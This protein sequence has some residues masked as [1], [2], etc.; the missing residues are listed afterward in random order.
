MAKRV[1][2]KDDLYTIL[3]FDQAD[4]HLAK[5][6]ALIGERSGYEAAANAMID[7]VKT[8]LKKQVSP[9][10]EKIQKHVRSLEAFC[11]A[12]RSDFGGRQSRSMLFGVVGWRKSTS[13][14][15]KKTTLQKIKDL[16]KQKA[17]QYIRI[18]EDADKEALARL[19]DE[20]LANV[21]A[22]RQHREVFFAEPDLVAVELVEH[23]S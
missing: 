19:T 11:A 9:L 13:I 3:T 14:T 20:Q 15:V 23:G 18:K 2:V 4:S 16:F 17:S 1:K 21:D 5:L 12:N 10:D 7:Q 22:R 6:G 8:D